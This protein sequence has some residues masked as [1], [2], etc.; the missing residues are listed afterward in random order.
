MRPQ[1]L[2]RALAVGIIVVA[3][4]NTLAALSLPVAERKPGIGLVVLW[5]S[6]L[7][8]HAAA[9][10]FG[11]ITRERL[12]LAWYIAMQA[13]IVFTF[14]VSGALFPVGLGLYIALTAETVL[15]AGPV[16]GALP[17]TL[18]A[19]LLFAAGAMLTHNL[20]F[21]AMAGLLLAMT[22]IVV[23]A[24]AGLVGRVPP[25]GT[26]VGSGVN[27]SVPGEGG[28]A[29]P[30]TDGAGAE[31]RG[32]TPREIEVL[33]AIVSGARSSQIATDLGVTERTVKAHLGSIYQKLGVDSRAAA[34]AIAV[35]RAMV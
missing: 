3:M 10:W 26:S 35:R 2:D 12:G 27:G 19:I 29:V 24:V 32:L 15:I 20:Y 30:R 9:Y 28:A 5:A 13:S 11:S 8:A 6:L 16:W 17:I 21:G 14:G 25:R 1:K 34:V 7:L 33:R 18:G 4:F 22:G 23:H 31:D